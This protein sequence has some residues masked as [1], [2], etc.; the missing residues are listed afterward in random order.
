MSLQTPGD[1]VQDLEHGFSNLLPPENN[2][3]S[4]VPSHDANPPS[5]APITSITLAATSLPTQDEDSD[6]MHTTSDTL[7]KR[8]GALLN[9]GPNPSHGLPCAAATVEPVPHEGRSTNGVPLGVD[10]KNQRCTCFDYGISAT[11]HPSYDATSNNCSEKS[12][13]NPSALYSVPY[14]AQVLCPLI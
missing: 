4:N 13:R 11:P 5:L 9:G 6:P 12:S 3:F 10:T 14:T 7:Y 1:Q 8:S 2:H